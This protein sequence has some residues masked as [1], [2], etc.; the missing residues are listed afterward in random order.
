[1]SNSSTTTDSAEDLYERLTQQMSALGSDI[2]ELKKTS[3]DLSEIKLIA[4]D[5]AYVRSDVQDIKTKLESHYV[6]KD[7][8]APVQ[9]IVYGLVAILGIATLTAIFRLILKA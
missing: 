6:T 7:T 8:F 5:V 3:R 9:R 4:N 1:M 2:Q